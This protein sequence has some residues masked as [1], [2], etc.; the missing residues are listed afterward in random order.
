[1][2][3][4]CAYCG[5][6]GNLSKEHVWPSGFLERLEGKYANYS[7]KSGKVHGGEYIVHDVCK[8]CNNE[9]LAPLDSY[10]CS[11]YDK[12]FLN[13]KGFNEEV[14]FEYDYD[15]LAR[16]LLKIAYNTARSAGSETS[17][18]ERIVDY[19]RD[20]R[21][22]SDG[23]A[24]IGELVA[25]TVLIESNGSTLIPKEIR[26][27]MH[28]SAL[29]MLISPNG[30]AVL[31]RMIAI[32]SFF[33]HLLIAREPFD[34]TIFDKAVQEFID[35]VSGA[36]LLKPTYKNIILRTSLQDSLSSMLPLLQSKHKEY[37]KFFEGQ[38]K[39]PTPNNQ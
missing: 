6:V 39:G 11:L 1:L 15:L 3:R 34:Q 31:L 36:V 20:G 10:F 25:P 16:A 8:I 2:S 30:H 23:F 32:N 21:I 38:Q 37:K 28:R 19:I 35:R 33:F 27:N 5:A 18:F 9:K 26:P 24:V 4:K 13:P 12:Y 7:P 29:A 17:P 22:R 14:V